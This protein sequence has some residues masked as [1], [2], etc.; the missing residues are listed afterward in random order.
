MGA[1]Q[2][3]PS[4]YEKQLGHLG[5]LTVNPTR[6]ARTEVNNP[7]DISIPKNHSYTTDESGNRISLGQDGVGLAHRN[8]DEFKFHMIG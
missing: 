2:F 1:V 8:P 5:G 6:V 7:Y 4:L 3:N